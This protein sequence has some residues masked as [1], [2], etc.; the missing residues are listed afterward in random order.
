MCLKLKKNKSPYFKTHRL[1]CI[2]IFII[3]NFFL[4][5]LMPQ[6][7]KS[8]Q[9]KHIYKILTIIIIIILAIKLTLL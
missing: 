9:L 7:Y 5:N 8:E 4:I 6:N 3:I 2:M 1:K